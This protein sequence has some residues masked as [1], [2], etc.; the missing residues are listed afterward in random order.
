MAVN[1][2][3]AAVVADPE[4]LEEISLHDR[5]FYGTASDEERLVSHIT[6][7]DSED[8]Y[9]S[10]SE[11]EGAIGRVARRLSLPEGPG[12]STVSHPDDEIGEISAETEKGCGCSEDCFQQFSQQEI[13][14]FKL[15][16]R[17]LS[18]GERDL[19]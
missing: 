7:R 2:T 6:A 13:L 19:F 8:E 16:K 9:L 15:S 10:P 1:C 5:E 3:V 14:D 4:T 11:D 18:K 12:A 17:E